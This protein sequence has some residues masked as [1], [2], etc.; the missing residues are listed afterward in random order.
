MTRRRV[1]AAVAACL[2]ALLLQ[3]CGSTP[4]Q[5]R[6]G[7]RPGQGSYRVGPPYQINGVWYYPRVDYDYDKT[8][9]ASWYGP[10]FDQ[11]PTANGEIFDM[12]A[13]TAAHKTLPLPSVVEV[14]NLQNGR[15]L[16]LRVNDRGPFVG[17][18]LIDVSR[19]AAQ[20][21][22]FAEQGT[23][24]VRVKILKRQSIE[25]AEAAMHNMGGT[26]V[27]A[28]APA[29]MAAAPTPR[30]APPPA[31]PPPQQ[32]A[33]RPLPPPQPALAD[34]VAPPAAA[35]PLVLA[36][37]RPEPQASGHYF[38]QAGAFAVADN[39]QRVRSRIADLGSIEIMPASV[40]GVEVYRVRLGPLSSREA[41]NEMLVRVIDSGYPGARI[42]SD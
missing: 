18:R 4:Q 11:R 38:V 24:P 6:Y 12:N 34:I 17:D 1:G 33:A 7:L 39:A 19:R 25:V 2:L 23:A 35:A 3:A 32:V 21:L 42:V 30:P 37:Y 40:N 36:A 29:A 14:T 8:G 31:T 15:A 10:G 26:L 9:V 16:Q 20:L 27:A 41:A 28:A 5:A 13:V 22:G